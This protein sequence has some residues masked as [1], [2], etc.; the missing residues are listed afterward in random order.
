AVIMPGTV[1][2]SYAPFRKALASS[3]SFGGSVHFPYDWRRSPLW[4]ANALRQVIVKTYQAYGKPVHLVGHSMGGLMIRA[5]LM[6]Y[7]DDIWSKIGRIV[8]IGTPHY[9]SPSIAGY[10]KN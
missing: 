4:S 2:I 1:D 3:M 9:G 10:L 8:F 5:A 6:K 7:G